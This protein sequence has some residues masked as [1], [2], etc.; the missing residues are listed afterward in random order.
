M[1]DRFAKMNYSMSGQSTY[2]PNFALL[3][4]LVW[5]AVAGEQL[6]LD[7]AR[8]AVLL[9]DSDDAM[10]LVEVRE[11]LSGRGWFDLH[12]PR[13]QPPI[14]Y[15]THWSRL[16]DAGLA[17]LFLIFRFF[18]DTAMAERLMRVVWPLLWI[19]P[20][21][22][23]AIA[24]AWRLGGRMAAV[25]LLLL[26]L[27][28]LP[29]FIQFKAGRI[30][31]HD[32]QITLALL[33]MAAAIWS[34]RV[35]WAACTAGI[36]SGLALAIGFEGMPFIVLAGA[37]F[38]IRYASSR[39]HSAALS[40]YGCSVAVSTVI[41]MLI[42]IAPSHWMTTAC[43]AIA[44]N[45]AIPMIIG[46]SILGI[47][48]HWFA[49]E[50]LFVRG[51]AIVIAV[52]FT[53][54]AFTLLEPRCLYGP[55]AMVD[56]AVKP[57]WLAHVKEAQ[58][59]FTLMRSDPAT[60]VGVAAY[61]VVALISAIVLAGDARLRRDNGAIAA[62]AA[63]L[64]AIA[65]TIVAVR[66]T[67]Y[68]LW[69]SMPFV[70]AILPRIFAFLKLTSLPARALVT[71]P[72]SPVV[73]L[74]VSIVTM[75]SINSA[76]P[77]SGATQDHPCFA[78]SNFAALAKLPTGLVV[79]DVDYGPFVLALTPHSVLGAPYHRLSY[80]ILASYRTFA[81]P[82]EQAREFVR[83]TH[84]NYLM[85]CGS[86]EPETLSETEKQNSLWTELKRGNI[87]E[88]LEPIPGPG[89]LNVYRVKP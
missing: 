79:T 51:I 15:D 54:L 81:S 13:L 58:S 9:G 4:G 66:A 74:W 38:V 7:W 80:G 31:H 76:Q 6:M 23:G 69:F 70:A 2:Q 29:A 62:A 59:L 86:R 47:A 49:D 57:I 21:I 65:M 45:S 50:R 1:W 85:I 52:G 63:L 71:I 26:L 3:V 11:F 73:I 83:Q 44:I 60:G 78:I 39:D 34:D 22:I 16:I 68:A 8:T 48:G 41:M 87:P 82:P 88:W 12:E 72:F 32:V 64:V 18:A 37:V 14:G 35:P 19:L 77:M 10:R 56:P 17:G 84:A 5:L 36:L 43:D 46:G 75:E 42:S 61:P 30:D 40:K 28:G 67:S 25:V 53:A 89:S 55:L 27:L 24:L 20:A 33:T